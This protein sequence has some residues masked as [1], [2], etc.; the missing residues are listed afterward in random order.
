MG[1]IIGRRKFIKIVLEGIFK[2]FPIC[3]LAS[4]IP[5]WMMQHSLVIP[6]LAAV[7]NVAEHKSEGHPDEKFGFD[8]AERQGGPRREGK[9]A[10]G[11]DLEKG[12]FE[13]VGSLG[14]RPIQGRTIKF[15]QLGNSV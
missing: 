14:K 10:Q 11:G 7:N 15:V 12:V 9:L 8:G 5:K 2:D 3:R 6:V 4:P 1:L 13:V